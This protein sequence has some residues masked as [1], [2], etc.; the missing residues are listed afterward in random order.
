MAA[1]ALGKRRP[2]G[3]GRC[4]GSPPDGA[5]GRPPVQGP[6][7]GP[8]WCLEP[9][10]GDASQALLGSPRPGPSQPVG[11]RSDDVRSLLGPGTTQRQPPAP[12]PRPVPRPS[13][14]AGQSGKPRAPGPQPGS[15]AR[16]A[17]R[18]PRAEGRAIQ[19]RKGLAG[20]ATT[21]RRTHR[22]SFKRKRLYKAS[23]EPSG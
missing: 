4:P 15:A 20:P 1:S 23:G 21:R 18:A 16:R 22:L 17:S 8:N 6:V 13:P 12:A 19:I 10:A 11:S 14:E 5:V 7:S 3:L 9:L 2:R